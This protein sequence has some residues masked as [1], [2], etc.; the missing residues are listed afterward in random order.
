MKVKIVL[1]FRNLIQE[2]QIERKHLRFF[3][4]AVSSL[5]FLTTLI[6]LCFEIRETSTAKGVLYA[7]DNDSGRAIQTSQLSQWYKSNHFAP[8]G[9]LYFRIAHT[10]AELSPE[11]SNPS[12]TKEENEDIRNHFA[13]ALTSLLSLAVFS[14]FLA[15]LILRDVVWSLL[16]GNVLFHIGII[17]QTWT[18]FIFRAHP[19][20]LL[21]LFI[22]FAIY[23]T[24]CFS[25]TFSR[26]DF[27][28]AGLTWGVATA[29]KTVTILFIPSFLFLFLSFGINKENFKQGINFIG[30]M[31]LAYLVIGFPQNFGFY[32]HLN[33]LIHESKASRTGNWSSI[34]QF[35]TLIF[36]QTK[37]LVLAFIPIHLLFGKQERILNWRILSFASISLLILF[38]RRMV[39]PQ[40][41]HPMPF[42]AM[43]L[44]LFIF[45]L[46]LIP[47]FKIR[48]PKLILFVISLASLFLL[49]NFPQ[50]VADQKSFQLKCREEV[51]SLLRI[52]KEIQKDG[53]SRLL[54]EPYFPFDSSNSITKQIWAIQIKDL[55]EQNAYLF[56]TR[57]DFGEQ[58]LKD[59]TYDSNIDSEKWAKN[60][61]F[62]QKVL[63]NSQFKTPEGRLF[64]KIHEDKCGFILFQVQR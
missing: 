13:L 55:D 20:H 26:R 28:L 15:Y 42:V 6:H 60:R 21:M 53:V 44:I 30:Y 41:H 31:L 18:Y 17:D 51:V 45:T 39:M 64:T 35:S 19:D 62:Y 56:G 22:G 43:I 37:Y 52:I 12:W 59:Y 9:N 10:L 40:T 24:L 57:R 29:T 25:F 3:V 33:F 34:L 1:F 54:K 14:I 50:A 32:K 16:L 46:K 5:F 38:S 7:T 36:D 8:Y 48:Y 63:K 27:I 23:F 61:E 4:L 58:F 2:A 49:N 47:P 11:L